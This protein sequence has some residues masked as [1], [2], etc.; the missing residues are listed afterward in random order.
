MNA[1]SSGFLKAP[2]GSPILG[3]QRGQIRKSCSICHTY[4]VHSIFLSNLDGL[5]HGG[6][7]IMKALAPKWL[8]CSLLSTP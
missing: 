4:Q 1:R 2:V 7:P 6:E 3:D 8:G 5:C